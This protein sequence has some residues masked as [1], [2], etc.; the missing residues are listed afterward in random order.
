MKWLLMILPVLV[1]FGCPDDS[2]K[3]NSVRTE[4]GVWGKVR[5]FDHDGYRYTV[6]EYGDYRGGVCL[7]RAEKINGAE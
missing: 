4:V 2:A 6:Y 7:L 5:T 3:G 1:L